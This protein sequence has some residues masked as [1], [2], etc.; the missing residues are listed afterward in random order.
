MT[1]TPIRFDDGA[2]Y[3]RY[4]G[5]WS[6]R[7]GQAF[8]DWLAPPSDQ[9]WLD[10]G[11][12]NG[13]FTE[14]IVERC[15]PSSVCGID[16]SA[17]QLAYARSRP[18]LAQVQW[19]PGD[20]MA[21]PCAD[22]TFDIA[23]M[24]LVIFFVPLPATGVAQMKRVVRP[25]GWVSAYAWDLT[26]GGFP[27]EVLL[28]ELRRLNIAVPTAPAPE[29]SRLEVMHALW[30]GAGLDAVETCSFTVQRRFASFEDFWDTA[31]C[32][33]SFGALLARLDASQSGTL[34]AWL[35]TQLPADDSGAIT[36]S[37]RAHAVKGRVPGAR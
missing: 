15:A 20:A 12:G 33:P 8:L 5:V 27:Y 26:G 16:P 23:V 4:M 35:R 18:A 31:L 21:L 6:Q 30:S 1:S 17:E 34:R 36:H 3:E 10:V 32:A 25:G 14:M 9:A 13:A 29:A 28:A 24:P 11:C 19:L 37:A 22:A 2:A 7:V